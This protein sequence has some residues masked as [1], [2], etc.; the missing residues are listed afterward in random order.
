MPFENKLIMLRAACFSMVRTTLLAADLLKSYYPNEEVI[1][2][3]SDDLA[4]YILKET[5]KQQ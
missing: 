3:I 4:K 2:N 5:A 1:S